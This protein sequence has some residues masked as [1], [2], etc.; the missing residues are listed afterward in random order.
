MR[1]QFV[2]G[3]LIIAGAALLIACN[4]SAPPAPTTG[5]PVAVSVVSAAYVTVPAVIEVP[6]SVQPRSRVALSAQINGSVREVT[7]RS[8]DTVRAGQLLVTLDARDADGQKAAAAAGIDE[9]RAALEEARKSAEMSA[10]MRDGAKAAADL[11]SATYARYQKLFSARSVSPQE[12]DEV[13]ARRDAAS[14]DLAARETV[15]AAAQDRLR[16]ATA[17]IAQADAQAARADVVLAWTRVKAP[18]AGRIA[19]KLVDPGSAIFPGSP[20]LVLEST[21]NPQVLADIPTRQSRLLLRGLE[22]RVFDTGESTAV[23]TGRI[24]EITPLSNPASHTVQFKVDLPAGFSALAGRFV[25]VAVPSGDR[26]ALLVP[27]QAV[28]ETGQLTGVFVVDSSSVARFRLVKVVP[29]DGERI[30]LLSGV[31]PG[32]KIIANPGI[33]ILDGTLLEVRK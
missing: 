17:R 5:R 29:Y 32:E 14:A 24:A 4:A 20:L 31:D 13:R 19:E 25:K 12:L 21:E 16:Q 28:R 15:V 11:A 23:V 30:E 18:A 10:S 33:E 27:R 1:T 2:Y 9:A 22:V 3:F 6:G 26:P 7:V 8:G